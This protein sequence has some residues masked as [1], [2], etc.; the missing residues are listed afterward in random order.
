MNIDKEQSQQ[1]LTRKTVDNSSGPKNAKVMATN[2][3]KNIISVVVIVSVAIS[4]AC[5]T[6]FSKSVLTL[7]PSHFY[8][9]YSMIYFSTCFMVICYPVF[10]FYA[11]IARR[12]FEETIQ[13]STRIFSPNGLTIKSVFI[14]VTPFIILWVAANYCY[15]QALGNISASGASSIM[16]SNTAIVCVLSWVLLKNSF[17]FI[18]LSAVFFAVG[19]VVLISLDSEFSGNKTGVI[20]VV[21]SAFTAAL[22][23]VLFKKFNGDASLGQVSLFMTIL[24]LFDLVFNIVPTVILVLTKVERIDFAYI[25]WW[26]LIGSALLGLLFNFLVNFGIALLNPLV[27]SIGMLCGIP[28]N[29]AIDIIFR[30]MKAT[31]KFLIG[32]S[33]ILISFILS[34]FPIEEIFKDKKCCK[35]CMSDVESQE[36]HKDSVNS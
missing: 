31:P 10:L 32:A 18:Q 3:K 21:A 29:A 27:I 34:T 36:P 30:D 7:D 33:L 5:A 26:P 2:F 24:G 22:Y 11:F 20:L 4:W 16:S 25:P 15:S 8:A 19:G 1:L 35:P 28:L 14:G 12:N 23:K 17:S 13:E 9:P 6:Q